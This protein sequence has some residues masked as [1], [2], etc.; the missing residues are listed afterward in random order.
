MHLPLRS[1]RQVLI[2]QL[3]SGS[4]LTARL[5]ELGDEDATFIENIKG[6]MKTHVIVLAEIKRAHAEV[7]FN[8]K[9]EE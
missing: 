9:D 8:R 4:T 1:P 3:Q 2:G 7:E 6:R 5:T